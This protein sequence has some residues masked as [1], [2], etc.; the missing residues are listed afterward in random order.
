MKFGWDTTAKANYYQALLG[1]AVVLG[2][3]LGAVGGGVLMKIGRRKA[4]FVSCAIG[5]VGTLITQY[6]DF[7]ALM[8]GRFIYGYSV[9]LFSAICPRI[10]EETTPP[11]I[12]ESVAVSFNFSQTMPRHVC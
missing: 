2:M 9:G 12:Y 11:H 6:F 8:I 10:L 7:T 3:A 4:L 1:A 5:I